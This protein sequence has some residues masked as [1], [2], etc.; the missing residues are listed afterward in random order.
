MK[1][2]ISFVTRNDEEC[3]E[4]S[5]DCAWWNEEKKVCKFKNGDR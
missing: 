1:C 4:S 5:D 3:K 2:D